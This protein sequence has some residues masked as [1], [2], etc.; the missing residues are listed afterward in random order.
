LAITKLVDE[1]PFMG[2][3]SPL[4]RLRHPP[5]T[6]TTTTPLLSTLTTTLPPNALTRVLV[7]VRL[8]ADVAV[9]VSTVP[10]GNITALLV[11]PLVVVQLKPTADTHEP[12]HAALTHDECRTCTKNDCDV[13]DAL[14]VPRAST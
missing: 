13:D 14:S 10:L 4:V 3:H 5:E 9:V 7:S 1:L 6:A 11:A 2:P 8:T 12:L